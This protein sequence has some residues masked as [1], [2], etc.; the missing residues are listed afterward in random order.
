MLNHTI[1]IYPI[2]EHPSPKRALNRALT[3]ET[4]LASHINTHITL[5]LLHVPRQKHITLCIHYQQTRKI[6]YIRPY[7]NYLLYTYND[8]M[9]E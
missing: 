4:K 3:T 2:L 5:I 1:Y 9:I 8:K 6:I 7:Y